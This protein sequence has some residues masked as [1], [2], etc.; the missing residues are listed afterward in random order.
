MNVPNQ[1]IVY[2]N[3][4][5]VPES[6]AKIPFRDRGVK[7]GDAVFDTTRTFGHEIFR[8]R[9]HLERFYRSLKYL[10]IDAGMTI[11]EFIAVTEHVVERNLPL[12]GKDEDYWVTQRVTR[13]ID[14]ADRTHWP[15]WD[16]P[17]I[18]VECLP[19]PLTARAA[20]YR[21]GLDIITP[22]VRR[23]APD[24]VS[25]RAK[26]H[27]YLNLILGDLEVSAQDPN[28]MAILL[29]E[30]GNLS[31]GKGSNIFL[32]SDG[33]IRTPKER[34]V[35]PGV[36]RAVVREMAEGLGL[37]FE[38]KD[39]DL[40]DA[41]N[42]EECFISSTSFCVCPVRSV[43]GNALPGDYPGPITRQIIDAYIAY[44]GFDWYAQYLNRL[45]A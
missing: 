31:E 14:T 21:D 41:Y 9:E 6:E 38:D 22:S 36:S 42:A 27:N 29:D 3:G 28:A 37:I 24:M 12:I 4:E 2:L 11:E 40:F 16:G 5:F 32:V 13:G 30:N 20:S 35:L 15:E 7:F 39:I 45:D 26:T 18:I 25:P 43:N 1:R 19:L 23:V 34:Y 33:V 17:T 44:V 10:R 8:L